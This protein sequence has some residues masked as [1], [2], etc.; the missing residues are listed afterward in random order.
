MIQPGG[1]GVNKWFLFE[2]DKYNQPMFTNH[3]WEA[4]DLIKHSLQ[5]KLSKTVKAEPVPVIATQ[6]RSDVFS[7]LGKWL[8]RS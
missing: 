2:S 6:V 8:K 3:R 7:R 5:F 4:T 1:R